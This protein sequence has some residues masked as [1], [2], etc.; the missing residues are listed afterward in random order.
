MVA[1]ILRASVALDFPSLRDAA[2]H[3]LLDMW[4]PDLQDYLDD[5]EKS[6][7]AADAVILAKECGL[8][9]GILKRA[10]CSL[11]TQP[12]LDQDIVDTDETSKPMPLP[13]SEVY[14]LTRARVKLLNA[15]DDVTILPATLTSCPSRKAGGRDACESLASTKA[16]WEKI[17]YQGGLAREWKFN[18]IEGLNRLQNADWAAEGVCG[19]CIESVRDEW[20]AKQ[21]EIWSD[22]DEWLDL[23]A[24]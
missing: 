5:T 18:P 13:S 17:V 2:T 24:A 12:E 14:L 6:F 9:A 3:I 1:S 21:E 15:W 4:N 8:P 7:Y 10:Y 22:L 20:K 11:L 16:A 23:D 19:R